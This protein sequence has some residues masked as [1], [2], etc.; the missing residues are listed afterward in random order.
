MRDLV[1]MDDYQ[2]ISVQDDMPPEPWDV[3]PLKDVFAQR[4]ED[5]AG[6]SPDSSLVRE[7]SALSFW[8]FVDDLVYRGS[9]KGKKEGELSAKQ[10]I[11]R[12]A[13][14]EGINPLVKEVA[15]AR[16]VARTTASKYIKD[17]E[18]TLRGGFLTEGFRGLHEMREILDAVGGNMQRLETKSVERAVE[19][20]LR[21][22]P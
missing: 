20:I 10:E 11:L 13:Y 22:H 2:E 12:D 7:E 8:R 21:R 16:D 9:E 4:R 5:L 15:D 6:A 19:N 18:R 1:T 3:M 14:R 17:A